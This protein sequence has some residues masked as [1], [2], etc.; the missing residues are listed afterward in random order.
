VTL[1]AISRST[2]ISAAASP[3]WKSPR[4]RRRIARSGSK[5][6][7]VRVL[8]VGLALEEL[9]RVLQ[10]SHRLIEIASTQRHQ[11]ETGEPIGGND[12]ADRPPQSIQCSSVRGTVWRWRS[13]QVHEFGVDRTGTAAS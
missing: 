3:A 6:R 4:E 7:I 11:V 5:L 13:T 9:P 10:V 1:F 12:S 2:V 8:A